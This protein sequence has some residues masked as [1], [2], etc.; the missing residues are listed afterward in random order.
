MH[1]KDTAC[2]TISATL[3]LLL[4]CCLA[5]KTSCSAKSYRNLQAFQVRLSYVFTITVVLLR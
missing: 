1:I 3:Y 4:Q 5:K 2:H